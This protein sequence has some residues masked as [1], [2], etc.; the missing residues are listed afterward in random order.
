MGLSNDLSFTCRSLRRNLGVAVTVWLTLGLG[1]G[2]CTAVFSMIHAVLLR[3]LPFPQPEQ[4]VHVWGVERQGWNRG[5]LSPLDLRDLR[6]SVPAFAQVEGFYGREF[7]LS[8]N[9]AEP[10]LVSGVR[11]T[12]GVFSALRISPALGR[13]FLPQDERPGSAVV[14]ISHGLW[15][16]RFGGTPQILGQSLTVHAQ[17]CAV[18]GVMP[19]G[20][21][22]PTPATELWLPAD[23]A[24]DQA[25]R[26]NRLFQVLARLR[27][28]TEIQTARTQLHALASALAATATERDR[29]RSFEVV[30]LREALVFSHDRVVLAAQIL[31]VAAVFALLLVSANV[32]NLLLAR[33]GT[34]AH[35]VAVRNAMGGSLGQLIRLLLTESLVLALLGGLSGLLIARWLV[36]VSGTLIPDRLYRADSFGLSV[37]AVGFAFFLALLV[38]GLVGLWPA[39]RTTRSSLAGTL[40]ASRLGS[41]RSRRYFD[42]LA[43]AQLAL[44]TLLLCAAFSLLSRVQHLQEVNPGFE[45]QVLSL[46]LNL[47]PSTYPTSI[48][49]ADFVRTARAQIAQVPGVQSVAAVNF[50]PLNHEAQWRTFRIAGQAAGAEEPTAIVLSVSSGYFETL[51]VPVLQGRDLDDRD[52]A[53]APLVVMVNRTFAERYLPPGDPV[54][55]RLAFEPAAGGEPRWRT[56]VGVVADYQHVDLTQGARPQVFLPYAQSPWAYLRLLVR[57]GV[58]GPMLVPSIRSAVAKVDPHL[59]LIEPQTLAQVIAE[60]LVVERF[61]SLALISLGVGALLLA[62]IGLYGVMA[63]RVQRALPEISLRMALG[64]DRSSVLRLV[65]MQ[66]IRLAGMGLVLGLFGA[67]GLGFGLSRFLG[68]QPFEITIY[69]IVG[70]VL[71]LVAVLAGYLPALSAS[72]ANPLSCAKLSR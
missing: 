4:L 9:D 53:T 28:E 68:T 11:V 54:G 32:A 15:Q 5:Y 69:A 30:P 57:A 62:T 44:G 46:R 14:L 48:A 21:A 56:V 2:V 72:R 63:Y 36:R 1:I 64:A 20:F 23:L 59:P 67:L 16:R 3:P 7:N 42:A 41:G 26:E 34:R 19:A 71:A 43:V 18:I 52:H 27:P 61:I 6:Q 24:P 31:S 25:T 8:S 13:G 70:V 45:P 10:E 65:L 50:L 37:P 60:S 39:L 35:E 33:F 58:P 29:D 40:A 51:A 38:A 22:F 12:A 17:P 55:A 66:A 49:Q 47:P